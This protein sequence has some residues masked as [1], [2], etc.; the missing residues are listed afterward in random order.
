MKF[1]SIKAL[2][3][4]VPMLCLACAA[5]SQNKLNQS[6]QHYVGQ[7]ADHVRQQINLDQFGYKVSGIPVETQ[8]KLSYT[9][10]RN[11]P[12]PMGTPNLGTS[13]AMGAPNSMQSKGNL[14][15]QMK[16]QIDFILR[17][18]QVESIEYAGKAC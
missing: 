5:T 11:M 16:C 10:L 17:D 18:D 15:I 3:L 6:L 4:A 9:I 7:S 14:N 8:G 13:I 12:I 2:I 1:N